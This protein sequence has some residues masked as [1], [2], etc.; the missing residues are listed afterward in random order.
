VFGDNRI[1]ECWY[2]P[3]YG[4]FVSNINEATSSQIF[5]GGGIAPGSTYAVAITGVDCLTGKVS[6]TAWGGGENI[7]AD[8][9]L[10]GYAVTNRTTTGCT[11]TIKNLGA[12]TQ[13]L[14]GSVVVTP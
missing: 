10:V 2:H 3:G 12:S 5:S 9:Y 8:A 6:V 11:V 13:T 4:W 1:Y 7:A 14:S